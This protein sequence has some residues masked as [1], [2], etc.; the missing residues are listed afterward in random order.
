MN[1]VLEK[2]L[3]NRKLW[4]GSRKPGLRDAHIATG[5]AVLDQFLPGGG[6]PRAALTEILIDKPGSGELQLVMPALAR[7]SADGAKDQHRWVSWIAPPFVP[8]APALADGGIK[9]SRMLIVHA[10][11][12][13]DVLWAAEQALRCGTC[14]AVL[15]W[16]SKA[17]AQSLRRLQ[18]A[19]EEGDSW[20]IVFRDAAARRQHS[21]A[22][23]R[24]RLLSEQTH[25]TLHLLKSRGGRPLRIAADFLNP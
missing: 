17:D 6:W 5:H 15:L 9:L 24:L 2:L 10:K 7:L 16:A 14:S 23:V 1:D 19:A 11:K 13:M 21:P 22:A 4:R 8:Y 20:G 18:L 25:K 12:G 3:D